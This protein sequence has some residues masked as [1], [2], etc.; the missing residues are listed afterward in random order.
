[1]S[2]V[3]NLSAWEILPVPNSPKL[4]N[5]FDT[6]LGGTTTDDSASAKLY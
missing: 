1:M 2:P 3:Q 5:L 6:K 4:R